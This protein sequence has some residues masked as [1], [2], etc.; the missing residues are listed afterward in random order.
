MAKRHR[1][2]TSGDSSGPIQKRVRSGSRSSSRKSPTKIGASNSQDAMDVHAEQ[3]HSGEEDEDEDDDED[4][5]D[6]DNDG[7]GDNGNGD[8]KENDSSESSDSSDEDQKMKV[9]SPPK[10]APK[11]PRAKPKFR[12]PAVRSYGYP[13]LKT[14]KC[15][16]CAKGDGVHCFGWLGWACEGCNERKVKCSHTRDDLKAQTMASLKNGKLSG[17]EKDPKIALG[18]EKKKALASQVAK[19]GGSS[20]E[21][22]KGKGNVE[23]KS[24][25]TQ[26]FHLSLIFLSL[27]PDHDS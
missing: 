16:S 1:S 21:K 19:P 23:G 11:A 3:T 22:R 7:D 5:N 20:K 10:P 13:P 18:L 4:D 24:N 9:D 12:K 26:P 27:H 15:A 25:V 2:N 8:E 6:G 17:L 14:D